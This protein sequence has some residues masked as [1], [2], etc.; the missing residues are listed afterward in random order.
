MNYFNPL[1]SSFLLIFFEFEDIPNST[2]DPE[3]SQQKSQCRFEVE[4]MLFVPFNIQGYPI[5]GEGASVNRVVLVDLI[6]AEIT[7]RILNQLP[8]DK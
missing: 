7:N 4:P 8:Q 2:P 5:A 6:S 1:G 3:A